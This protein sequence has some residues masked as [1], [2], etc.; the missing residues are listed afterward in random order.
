MPEGEIMK[1]GWRTTEFWLALL[2]VGI[3]SAGGATGGY[4]VVARLV[5]DPVGISIVGFAAATI[6]GAAAVYT[7]ARV[8]TKRDA[9]V[10]LPPS[11]R[12]L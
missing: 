11:Q 7:Q 6:L 10:Q 4:L 9:T 5:P 3:G 12:A 2:S 8:R 1:S